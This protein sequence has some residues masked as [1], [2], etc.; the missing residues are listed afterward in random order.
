[1]FDPGIPSVLRRGDDSERRDTILT[2]EGTFDRCTVR[3]DERHW[4]RDPTEIGS[5]REAVNRCL[6]MVAIG[7]EEPKANPARSWNH[8]LGGPVRK[9]QP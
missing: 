4:N 1:M 5:R 9:E 6:V 7:S 2:G 3:A 8:H